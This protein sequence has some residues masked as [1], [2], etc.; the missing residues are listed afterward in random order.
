[1]SITP[2]PQ[3][4]ALGVSMKRKED[5]R[6]LQGKGRYVDDINLPGQLYMAI[7]HSPYPHAKINSIDKEPALAVPGVKAVITGEDLVAAGLGWLPTFHGFD[8]QMVLAVGKAL[9]QYQEVAAVFATSREAA[10]DGAELVEIDYE[11]LDP[12]VSPHEAA[13]DEV[14]IRSDR[15]KSTNHIY[16]WDVGHKDETQRAL[17][18]AEKVVK[19][20][21]VF[22]RCHPAPLEPC[23]CVAE[24]DTMGRLHFYVTS[25]A[26]HVYRTAL[27]LVT[28]IP[29]DKIHVVSPDIGGGFGNKV[30]VYPGYVCAVVG[31]LLLKKPVKWIETRTENLTTTGFARDYHMDVEIGAKADGTVTALRVKTV[32]DHGAFDAAADP[33]KYPAGMFGIVTGS[34]QFPVAYAELDAYFTN[35]AP[36]G[37][38]YRCSFRVTEASY[39][40]ERAM[41]ILAD[42]LDMDPVELRKK[43]FV[44][45]DQ[46]PYQS[47]LGFTYDSGDYHS[48]LD[49][50]LERIGYDD[51]LRE[52]AEKR[53]RGELMGIGFSTFT[54]VVGAGP[55]KHFDILGIKMFDSA[56][57][58]IHPTG[59]GV[60]RAGTKSQ[61]QGHE[62]T[63]AQIVAEELG[64]DPQNIMVEEGDTDTAPYGLGT[65]AS[66]ST[67]VAGAAISLAARR[68]REKAR[69]IAAHLLEASPEDVEWTDY[70]F[71]IKGVPTRSVTMKDVAFAA[72]T[73]PGDNEPGLE[74]SYYYDPPNMTFPHGTYVAVVDVDRHTGETKVRRFLAV[75][76]CGTVI[77]PMVVEGQIHGGLTE[78]YAI[79]FMQEIT[80]DES[81]NNLNPN[82]ID[83]LVP[84]SLEAP[85]W[86]TD[87]TVTPSPHHPIGAKGVGE[88]P[89]VGSPAAFVNAVMDA[90]S[91]L[92][93]RHVD[94]PLTREKVWRAIQE[95]EARRAISAD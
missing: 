42:E 63:W 43:N 86:E 85:K 3:K 7:V 31:S 88:S 73:N 66:R 6:F 48:T 14:V 71:Q 17:E 75:D 70:K 10:M 62:T 95:A 79:A 19:Q 27:A 60:V 83:Y 90:L 89:N 93:V 44:R 84:T 68:I 52:Q 23:G 30:P 87:N 55:S 50:A 29:E 72:Y 45:K 9:F 13:K 11:P 35:K 59:S 69:K 21:I 38:A 46:F 2:D 22:Q 94:M 33:T 34:Y 91:P 49:K 92:G 53:A 54:E 26:P 8:K 4:H 74:A 20:R 28:G 47:A 15:E 18:A 58:R 12:V 57:I 37:V 16:H 82:F 80:Y 40:I 77:N 36:G 1:M 64:L 5:P 24:F 81:G 65:Y 78:G 76:D 32:A 41:D 25:Q 61:G 56:E 39:A 67:P 51:L